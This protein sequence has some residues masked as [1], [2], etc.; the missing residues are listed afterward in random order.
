MMIAFCVSEFLRNGIVKIQAIV[1]SVRSNY[2][3]VVSQITKKQRIEKKSFDF[4]L[5][6]L[7]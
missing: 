4:A 6:F 1:G 5:L 7:F 2:F 3:F